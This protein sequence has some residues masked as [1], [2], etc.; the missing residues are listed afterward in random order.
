[1]SRHPR[2]RLGLGLHPLVAGEHIS[3]RRSFEALANQTAFIG[4]VGLDFSREGKPT[5]DIQVESFAFV[6]HV[7]A[8]KPKLISVHSRR[9]EARVLELLRNARRSPVV[10][11]WYSGPLSV[12]RDAVSDGHY[13]SINPAMI[14]SRN[15]LQITASLPPDRVL[16]E[17]DGPF[18]RVGSRVAEPTDVRLVE[19][20][21]ARVWNM[22]LMEVRSIVADNF[23]RLIAP[24]HQ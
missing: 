24:L 5:A 17:T 9:A 21:L 15:G 14:R 11:H 10:F 4:E 7:L 13:F 19:E 6:L 2:I 18:V 20:G 8:Q 16:T 3:Q 12:L 1:M 23:R 22:S